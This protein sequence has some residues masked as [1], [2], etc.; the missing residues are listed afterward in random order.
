[1]AKEVPTYTKIGLWGRMQGLF[2]NPLKFSHKAMTEL[3][4]FFKM[5]L[6]FRTIYITSNPAVFKHVLQSNNKNYVKSPAYKELKLALG[7]GLVTSEG[8][9]WRKQ[10]RLAQPAFHKKRLEELFLKMQEETKLYCQELEKECGQKEALDISK[11]M[12]TVTANIVLSTL[13]S[14]ENK[15]D[16]ELLY[17][18]LNDAQEYVLYRTNY[19]FLIPFCYINGKHRRF[20]KQLKFFDDVIYD[21]IRER[22]NSQDQHFDLLTMLLNARDEETGEGMSDQQLRDEIITLFVA[23]H[24]TSANALNWTWYALAKNPEIKSKLRAEVDRV[25]GDRLPNFEDLKKLPY[26]RQVLE[27]S[28]RLF[29][30][31]WALGRECLEEDEVIGFKIAKKAILLLNIHALHRHPEYWDNPDVFDPDRFSEEKLKTI[32]RNQYLPFGTGPRMCIGNH[33]AMM[34]MQLLLVSIVQKFDFILEE[35]HPVEGIPLV[36]YKPKYGIKMWV[37]RRGNQEN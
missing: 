8:D 9:F 12:M 19:P 22:K 33:F 29:P 24:E 18:S 17:Q 2:R 15:S 23:G 16:L 4:D 5:N 11:E 30:P 6:G 7:N 27:E 36:V 25:L 10:R 37:K 13:F 35:Q 28:M 26:T 3:G 20:K 32:A 1:M 14:S 31:A 34:E 21:L